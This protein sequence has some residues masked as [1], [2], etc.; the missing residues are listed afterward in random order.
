MQDETFLTDK[1]T[2]VRDGTRIS[3]E[4]GHQVEWAEEDNYVF[5]LGAFRKE[6]KQWLDANDVIRPRLFRGHLSAFLDK[7]D[8]D[9]QLSV[10]RSKAR[11]K[12][13]I[14]VPGDESQVVYVWLD[15]LANYLTAAT[16]A[17]KEGCWP[18]DVHLIGKD[19]LKFHCVYWPAFLMAAGLEL[20]RAVRVHSHWQV[21]GAKMSKSKGNVVDPRDVINRY[22]VD[23]LRYFLLRE[24]VPHSD[25]NYSEAKMVGYLNAELANTL[26]NLLSRCT[27]KGVN[28]NQEYV[29][30]DAEL[31]DKKCSEQGKKLLLDL[32][33]LADTVGSH[34]AEF[35]YYKGVDAIMAMLRDTN[36]FVQDEKPWELKKTDLERLDCVLHVT[37]ECL[38]VAG[39]LLQP[40]TPTLATN[41]LDKLNVDEE[42]RL[43]KNAR[44]G[45]INRTRPL[46][47]EK[48]VLY[49][50]IK[51]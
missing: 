21:D 1:Q 38:R 41:L 11:L 32:E 37:C 10:S 42:E 14:P 18:A 45:V 6:V 15:A 22:G 36:G 30:V 8:G 29:I 43:W 46:S 34:Y 3:L 4:S 28:I 5:N 9:F 35:E 13:G 48:T 24:G 2:D 26:G 20:P 7:E 33:T 16:R 40:L 27:A 51:A 44:P 17:A 19:I 49:N 47:Q 23:G 39:V 31:L 25:G 50:R 12:W